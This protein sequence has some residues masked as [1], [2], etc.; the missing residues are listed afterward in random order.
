LVQVLLYSDVAH[1]P[2][3]TFVLVSQH[4]CVATVGNF[5]TEDAHAIIRV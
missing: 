4:E 3:S 1:I 5:Y 2:V